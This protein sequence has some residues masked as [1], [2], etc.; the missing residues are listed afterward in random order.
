MA[1]LVGLKDKFDIA[2]GNDPDSD[3]HGIVTP[4]VGL[5]NPN[6]YL[7]VAIQYLLQN[8]PQWKSSLAV[9]KTLVS[10]GLIDRGGGSVGAQARRGAGGTRRLGLV[11]CAG[12]GDV[13]RAGPGCGGDGRAD[14]GGAGPTC[15]PGQTQTC[16]GC[17]EQRT[18]APANRAALATRREPS[19]LTPGPEGSWP[20]GLCGAGATGPP[21]GTAWPAISREPTARNLI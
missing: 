4:S 5:L 3:R 6:H 2:F 1:S 13:F 12:G 14:D 19:P 11:P 15:N 9:G 20:H 17:H 21:A 16:I 7:A 18:T 10:S 8:R